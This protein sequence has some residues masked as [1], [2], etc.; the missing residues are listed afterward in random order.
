MT[1]TE[2]IGP[3]PTDLETEYLSVYLEV[4]LHEA[5]KLLTPPTVKQ[6]REWKTQKYEYLQEKPSIRKPNRRGMK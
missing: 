4:P 6:V 1:T 5:R 2:R 3:M